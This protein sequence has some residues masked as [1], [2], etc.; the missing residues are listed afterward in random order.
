[1]LETHLRQAATVLLESTIRIA[2]PDARD[3]GRGMLG[4]LSQV[5]GRWAVA[6]WALGGVSVMARSTLFSILIPGRSG[7]N[8]VPDGGFFAKR[9]PLR[10]V[11]LAICGLFVLGALLFFL[12]PPFRQ[13][14]RT[15]L[16]A[17]RDFVSPDEPQNQ[18]DLMALA[19]QAESKHDAEGMAFVAARL[20]N[21]AESARLAERAVQLDPN[22]TWIYVMANQPLLPKAD[23]VSEL[24]HW[25]PENALPYLIAAESVHLDR[26][27]HASKSPTGEGGRESSLESDPAWHNAIAAVFASPK[28][29]DYLDRLREIDR[30]TSARYGFNNLYEMI[31]GEG[32]WLPAYGMADIQRFARS[33]LLS[34]Q[35]LEARGDMKGARDKYWMVARFGQAMDI[36][37]H[38]GQVRL[39]GA[40]LQSSAYSRLERLSE[41]EGNASEAAHFAYLATK[42]APDKATRTWM[43]EERVFG[44]EVS[45]RNATVLQIASLLL[46][47]F[48]GVSAVAAVF[49]ILGRRDAPPRFKSVATGALLAGSLGFLL[50]TATIYLTYRPYWYIFQ[51]EIMKGDRS[52]AGDLN[53]FLWAAH[54]GPGA[55]LFGLSPS[56]LPFYFWMGVILLGMFGLALIFLRHFAGRPRANASA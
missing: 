13:G 5:E 30:K 16:L 47:L 40:S 36:K 18:D 14:A 22:L 23:W 17:W 19:I 1:M 12:A 55:V 52:H 31:L 34:G 56:Y 43:L 4:E 10:K 27:V 28:F 20:Q 54:W 51:H 29:D 44:W 21:P 2:P 49:L 45:A 6:M 41:V 11:M 48:T 32:V 26:L 9:F 33:L 37:A 25:D 46:L 38:T 7:Q 3:W 35:E 8:M 39:L 24:K 15:S 50:S 42:L 53:D